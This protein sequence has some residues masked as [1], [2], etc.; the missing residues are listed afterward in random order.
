MKITVCKYKDTKN[1][2]IVYQYLQC[3]NRCKSFKLTA[4]GMEKAFDFA[5][6]TGETYVDSVSREVLPFI[7]RPNHPYKKKLNYIFS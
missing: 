1:I 6:T 2:H 7:E 4:E 3:R 5:Q